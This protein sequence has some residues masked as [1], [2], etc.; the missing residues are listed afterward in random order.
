MKAKNPVHY[1]EFE[2]R[3]SFDWSIEEA[4][5]LYSLSKKQF[6]QK[7][8]VS[9]KLNEIYFQDCIKGMKN[10]PKNSID[11]IIADPPF[12]I[13]FSGDKNQHGNYNRK[14][15]YVVEGYQEIETQNYKEF[16]EKWISQAIPLLKDT[17]SIW[18]ISGYNNL[19]H[20]ENAF[21][22]HQME[23]INH[24]IWQ[25]N[26]A[27]FCKNSFARCH[28]HLLYYA[29]NP[30]KRFFN[31]VQFYEQ[32][33]WKINREFAPGK[34][35]NG[36]KLPTALIQKLIDFTSKPGDIILDPFMGNGTTAIVAKQNYRHYLGVEINKGSKPII[37]SAINSL[38]DGEKYIPYND[39]VPTL[40][41]LSKRPG[42]QKAYQKYC[43]DNGI[44]IN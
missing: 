26:F 25:Y 3:P 27:V 7:L 33:T 44:L 22:N 43:I 18:V 35:K 8:C 13:N 12:G 30:S 41:E 16:T 11:L 23:L 21:A 10:I 29:K 19:R 36:T 6:K 20:V 4:R 31:R 9:V 24:C 15:E 1:A 5:R 39:R 34:E 28:Y 42:Y 2:F 17:G 14:S 37:Q 32:D 38:K 40:E